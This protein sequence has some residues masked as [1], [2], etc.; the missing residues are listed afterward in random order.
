MS[1]PDSL[2]I[3]PDRRFAIGY[4]A[5]GPMRHKMCDD[6]EGVDKSMIC[7]SVFSLEE[8][9]EKI[10][11]LEEGLD[12]VALERLRFFL[13][14][15]IHPGLKDKVAEVSFE[16]RVRIPE[17]VDEAEYGYIIFSAPWGK[18]DEVRVLLSLPMGL[19]YEH[20]QACKIDSRL[21]LPQGRV[22]PNVGREWMRAGMLTEPGLRMSYFREYD[23]PE[24]HFSITAVTIR[25]TATTP[26]MQLYGLYDFKNRI[27]YMPPQFTD[28]EP[29]GDTTFMAVDNSNSPMVLNQYGGVFDIF[30]RHLPPVPVI[31][32]TDYRKRVAQ[33]VFEGANFYYRD[34]SL[35]SNRK[36]FVTGDYLRAAIFTDVTPYLQKPAPGTKT[37]FLFISAHAIP[38]ADIA[39]LSEHYPETALWA[40]HMFHYNDYFRVMDVYSV[41]GVTQVTLLHMPPSARYLLNDDDSWEFLNLTASKYPGFDRESIV[42]KARSLFDDYMHGELHPMSLNKHWARRTH[43]RPFFNPD[44]TRA[45]LLPL[46]P[47][48][49]DIQGFEETIARSFPTPPDVVPIYH[50]EARRINVTNS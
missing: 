9:E 13:V 30:M 12:D 26:K 28:V 20:V 44:G 19:Y 16:R 1:K 4:F 37:R 24:T 27:T 39:D 10:R 25:R 40:I 3:D 18:K 21:Q 15:V 34:T 41:N 14:N 49:P 45:D 35:K 22:A 43:D 5:K 38:M 42:Q 33:W 17:Y 47:D 36:E 50:L 8:M 31:D 2:Y 32:K 11:I 46:D 29:M 7:R 23:V 6:W 48:V